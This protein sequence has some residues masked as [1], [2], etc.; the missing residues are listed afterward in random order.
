MKIVDEK[1]LEKMNI[2]EHSD[3]IL[4]IFEYCVYA[5]IIGVIVGFAG[6]YLGKAISIVTDYRL[7][8]NYIIYFLPIAGLF[9]IFMYH[10]AHIHEEFGT[11][12]I[13]N[14]IKNNDQGLPFIAAPLIF[15]AT[16]LTH[17]FGGSAGRE[18]AALLLG[19][20]LADFIG[21]RIKLKHFDMRI[22]TMCGMAA[23]FTALFGTP[24]AACLFALEILANKIRYAALLPVFLSS[25]SCKFFAS[26][27]GG[28]NELFVLNSVPNFEF[29]PFI[30][31]CIL[32]GLA[33]AVSILMCIALEKTHEIFKKRIN[34][35]YIKVFVGGVIVAS[36]TMLFGP[37]T[38]A[39]AGGNIINDALKGNGETFAFLIKIVLTSITLAV[40]FKGGEIVPSLFVGASF[41]AVVGPLLNLDPGFA[42]AMA[43][44][45]VFAG[46][47]NCP[48]A[49]IAL[50]VELFN[51]E[52]FL[53]FALTIIISYTLSG[54]YS[55]YTNQKLMKSKYNI[56]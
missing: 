56:D 23:G 42:A 31:T 18:S 30:K 38:Y 37:N 40:G 32:A 48:L 54:N 20:S 12:R 50:S 52:G 45:G 1:L 8:H 39:G 14:T 53:F 35:P 29:V 49:A 51:G 21:R 28:E 3:N 26:I 2:E 7:T 19:A 15:I 47:T 27:F 9:I 16:V 22:I 44:M 4:H 10:R 46:N 43:M 55:L 41:G 34:N 11:N 6:T 5:I 13:L 17:L 36:L 33:S 24:F 25:I